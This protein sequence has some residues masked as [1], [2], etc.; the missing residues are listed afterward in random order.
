MTEILERLIRTSENFVVH[1][2]ELRGQ[3]AERDVEWSVLEPTSD[4]CC[5]AGGNAPAE[6][7][8]FSENV[9]LGM[10]GDCTIF[11]QRGGGF[12]RCRAGRRLGFSGGQ[13]QR[14]FGCY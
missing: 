6:D 12:L 1:R 4:R 9:S 14:L 2:T 10:T 5:H 8:H 7:Y 11:H 13:R 3:P